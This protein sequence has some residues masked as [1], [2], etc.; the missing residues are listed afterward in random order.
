MVLRA[1]G[2]HRKVLVGLRGVGVMGCQAWPGGTHAALL[3]SYIPKMWGLCP[4]SSPC[5]LLAPPGKSNTE[6]QK[7]L[8]M[9][10]QREDP[11]A[12]FYNIPAGSVSWNS[13]P[14]LGSFPCSSCGARQGRA[15]FGQHLLEGAHSPPGSAPGAAS[16]L[17][18]QQLPRP[19]QES[20]RLGQA[21]G[22]DRRRGKRSQ[23]GPGCWL[24]PLSSWEP[25]AGD[26]R[27][28]RVG[29]SRAWTTPAS[30]PSLRAEVQ[31]TCIPLWAGRTHAPIWAL[32]VTKTQ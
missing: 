17:A 10:E 12:V 8:Q 19:A 9:A 4:V 6:T 5:I 3:R 24:S 16:P 31:G 20:R 27:A 22:L 14:E 26:S 21:P 7:R 1:L 23:R 15:G 18:R 11:L 25:G 30:G 28:E 13:P 32:V 29:G 2:G